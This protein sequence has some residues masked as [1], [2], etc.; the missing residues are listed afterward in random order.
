MT[1]DAPR[2][3]VI[4]ATAL[5]LLLALA[6]VGG[7]EHFLVAVLGIVV[8]AL[9]TRILLLEPGPALAQDAEIMVRELQIILGLH[10]VAGQLGVA[11]HALVLFE[12]LR[13]V[14]ALAIVLPVARLATAHSLG[15][16]P[17]AA[18]PAAA[19]TIIDQMPTSLPKQ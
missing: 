12:Q 15:P 6:L 8:V 5:L 13:G 1:T 10:A 14:A 11:R 18:A 16:L 7:L 19:L 4:I 2:T 3:V 9:A 17:A